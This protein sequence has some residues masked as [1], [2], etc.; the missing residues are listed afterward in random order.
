VKV[1]GIPLGPY[2][3]TGPYSFTITRA[4][5]HC[6]VELVAE[7]VLLFTPEVEVDE[8]PIDTPLGFAVTMRDGATVVA[9]NQHA[10][11]G[12]PGLGT[13]NFDDYDPDDDDWPDAHRCWHYGPGGEYLPD[14]QP[15]I[16]ISRPT[17]RDRLIA[18]WR[19]WRRP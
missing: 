4:C 14:G 2:S 10:C 19:A 7:V 16:R 18:A 12:F 17:V 13:V 6:N 3:D 1:A 9:F 8:R 11:Y 5:P 15:R